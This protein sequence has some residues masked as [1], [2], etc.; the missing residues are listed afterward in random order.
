MQ[1]RNRTIL[2]TGGSSGIGLELAR[3]LLGQNNTVLICGRSLEKLQKAQQELPN[4]HIFQCDLA[5]AQARQRLISWLKREHSE[6]R[7]GLTKVLWVI[8]RLSPNLG[9]KLINR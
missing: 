9:L 1:L 3:Q 2:I 4:L 5:E 6:I 8:S 7:V